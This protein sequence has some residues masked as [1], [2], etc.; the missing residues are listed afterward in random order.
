MRR[1]FA[2]RNPFLSRAGFDEEG[3]GRR[4]KGEQYVAIPF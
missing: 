3:E 4:V 1:H 2:S